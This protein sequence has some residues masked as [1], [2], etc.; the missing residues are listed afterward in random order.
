MSSLSNYIC[1]KVLT[2]GIF[3]DGLKFSTTK[4]LSKKGNKNYVSNYRPVSLLTTFSKMFAIQSRLLK[5]LQN[6][7]ILCREQ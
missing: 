6:E 3:P 2:K 5:H 7:N 4:P 1:N